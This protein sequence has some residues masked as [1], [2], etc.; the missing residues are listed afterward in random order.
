MVWGCVGLGFHK[1][2]QHQW[3]QE[4]WWPLSLPTSHTQALSNTC[5]N[6]GGIHW[7]V[8]STQSL[9]LPWSP[10][11]PSA[12]KLGVHE[13]LCGEVVEV[14]W[15]V[16]PDAAMV[17]NAHHYDGHHDRQK[18]Y[19][20]LQESRNHLIAQSGAK[21][22][23]V[24]L[25][26]LKALQSSSAQGRVMKTHV[27]PE[28]LTLTEHALDRDVHSS[29]KGNLLC[30]SVHTQ[31][32]GSWNTFSPQ[33]QTVHRKLGC[34]GDAAMITELTRCSLNSHPMLANSLKFHAILRFYPGMWEL[35]FKEGVWLQNIFFRWVLAMCVLIHTGTCA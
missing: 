21:Y 9:R 20:M 11:S 22:S 19:E 17:S 4:G 8:A 1:R 26:W 15:T 29:Q 34:Y 35:V 32:A 25:W 18:G 30:L 33:K 27:D 7:T 2:W 3:S 10:T 28:V 23:R 24:D 16:W 14:D 12:D 5:L 31:Y 6:K 13:L